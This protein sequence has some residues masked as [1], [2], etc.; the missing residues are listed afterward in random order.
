MVRQPSLTSRAPSVAQHTPAQILTQRDGGSGP[1][2][3]RRRCARRAAATSAPVRSG[4]ASAR[5]TGASAADAPGPG[6]RPAGPITAR[7]PA[8]RR[9]AT[10]PRR[11]ARR[12]AARFSADPGQA[13]RQVVAEP[14][15]GFAQADVENVQRVLPVSELVERVGDAVQPVVEAAAGCRRRV[16]RRRRSQSSCSGRR[17]APVSSSAYSTPGRAVGEVEAAACWNCSISPGKSRS[18]RSGVALARIARRQ[19]RPAARCASRPAPGPADAG[20]R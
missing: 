11:C 9:R 7:R 8:T 5:R 13:A 19:P 12:S 16:R 1:A 18:S 2:A 4:R 17:P 14:V 6:R 15:H 3:R 20:R 10:T